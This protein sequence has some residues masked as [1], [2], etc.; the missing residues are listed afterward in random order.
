M[1]ASF[2]SGRLSIRDRSFLLHIRNSALA[3]SWRGRPQLRG[4]FILAMI[5][6]FGI[7]QFSIIY[8]L[9]YLVLKFF[10]ICI[11]IWFLI[12]SLTFIAILSNFIS[13]SFKK[14]LYKRISLRNLNEKYVLKLKLIYVGDEN[15]RARFRRTS[16][17]CRREAKNFSGNFS[18]RIQPNDSNFPTYKSISRTSGSE[19]GLRCLHEISFQTCYVPKL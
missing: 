16:S 6:L 7:K 3:K 4:I 11:L 17:R 12:F 10:V 14:A 2:Y 1:F 5:F 18:I 15:E 8:S 9:R 19:Q 13:L